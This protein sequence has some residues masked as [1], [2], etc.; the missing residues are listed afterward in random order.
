MDNLAKLI[1]EENGKTFI[2]SKGDVTRGLEVVEHACG[3]SHVNMG[4]TFG[5]ISKGIDCYSY[6]VP[7]GVCGGICPF[8]FPAMIP[9]WM[10]P[11]AITLGNT[12]VIKGSEKVSKTLVRLIELLDETKLPKGVL[13]VV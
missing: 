13:N 5:N 4:E 2:D 12:F 7:L 11:F 6:R 10:F 3:L 8:N 1:V 9:L